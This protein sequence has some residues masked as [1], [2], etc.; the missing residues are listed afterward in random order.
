VNTNTHYNKYNMHKANMKPQRY[1]VPVPLSV[2]NK[3]AWLV[4]RR[5]DFHLYLLLVGNN[6][7]R[8][9]SAAG[10]ASVKIDLGQ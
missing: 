9:S 6:L 7:F 8:A 1:I 10:S 3:A 4:K 5:S 2:H